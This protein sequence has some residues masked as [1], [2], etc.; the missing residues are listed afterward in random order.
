MPGFHNSGVP[1]CFQCCPLGYTFRGVPDIQGWGAPWFCCF[2]HGGSLLFLHSRISTLFLLSG[3]LEQRSDPLMSEASIHTSD[4]VKRQKLSSMTEGDC[5]QGLCVLVL[6][7]SSFLPPSLSS[8]SSLPL[9]THYYLSAHS[10]SSYLPATQQHL[11]VQDEEGN[12]WVKHV[13]KLD[14]YAYMSSLT[15][16]YVFPCWTNHMAS[17]LIADCK[18]WLLTLIKGCFF[19]R[20]AYYTSD[21]TNPFVQCRLGV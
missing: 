12:T 3:I 15:N 21:V 2:Q 19:N 13:V 6:I 10:Q 18:K 1:P 11:P 8:S 5:R 7:H 9:P 4:V 17:L 20:K 14:M 16:S